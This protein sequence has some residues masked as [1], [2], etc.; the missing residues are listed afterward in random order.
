MLID[1]IRDKLVAACKENGMGVEG[2]DSYT[3]PYPMTIQQYNQLPARYRASI[4]DSRIV[5]IIG[6]GWRRAIISK[7]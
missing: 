7:K 6:L 4:Q 3:E 5:F 1:E 2:L